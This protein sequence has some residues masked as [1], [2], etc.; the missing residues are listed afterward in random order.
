[1]APSHDLSIRSNRSVQASIFSL[2]SL[3]EGLKYTVDYNCLNCVLLKRPLATIHLKISTDFQVCT[4]GP[5][6]LW[7]QFLLWLQHDIPEI[8]VNT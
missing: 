3:R 5:E 1:M 8:H 7:S 4:V 2:K 6:I